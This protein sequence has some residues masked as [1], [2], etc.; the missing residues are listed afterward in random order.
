MKKEKKSFLNRF[1]GGSNEP[2][3]QMA[4]EQQPMSMPV[5]AAEEEGESQMHVEQYHAEEPEMV[6]QGL[7]D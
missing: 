1:S 3:Q 7:Y 5:Y 6:L 2:E 4:Q